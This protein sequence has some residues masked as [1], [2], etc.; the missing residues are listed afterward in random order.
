MRLYDVSDGSVSIDGQ[1]LRSITMS[2]VRAAIGTVAQDPHL[3]HISVGD[4]LRY[5]RPGATDEQLIAACESAQ[6][7]D[8]IRRL[9]EGFDTIVG[10]RGYRLSGGEKQRL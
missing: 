9:P 2:S 10:E 4:N 5:G 6:I 8:V 7:L 1:D 3:F